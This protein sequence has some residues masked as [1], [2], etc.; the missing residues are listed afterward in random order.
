MRKGARIS[1]VIPALNEE[2]SIGN[3]LDAIPPWVDEVIVG[4]NGSTDGTV[5]VARSHGATVATANRRG[6]GS[7]CLAA[8]AQ[9]TN[10]DIVVYLDGDF[11]DHPEQM[12]RLV[13]PIVEGEAELVIGSRVLGDHDPGALTP[14]ARFGNQLACFLMRLI[15]GVRY[16]DLGPFRAI[17]YESLRRL[18]MAD[19]DYGW[20]VEMQIKAAQHGM[21]YTEAPVD[22][23][24]RIG[25]SKV[26]GTLRGII[27]AGY[28]ILGTI[29]VSA[30]RHHFSDAKKMRAGSDRVVVFTRYPEPGCTK[31]RLIP[32]LGEQGAA[33][34]QRQMTKRMVEVARKSRAD[35]TVIR[36]TGAPGASFEDWLGAGFLYTDQGEG[37]LGERMSRAFVDAF[38][39]GATRVV[40]IGIDCPDVSE[41]ILDAALDELGRHDLVLGPATD[42]GYYLIGIRK[43]AQAQAIPHLFQ[44]VDWG[45]E[46]V[47]AQTEAILEKQSLSSFQ[48]A[49]LDDVDRPDDLAVW[50]RAVRPQ[51]EQPCLSIVIPTL[52]EDKRIRDTIAST[53]TPDD[54][55]EIIV[56][57]G[58]STDETVAVARACG[59]RVFEC[60]PGR[61]RQMN[62][63]AA[64]ASGETLLFLH[65]DTHLPAGYEDEVR[66]VLELRGTALGAFQ[67]S[68]P[69]PPL[70]MRIIAYWANLRSRW[71][72]T[73]YGDQA[74]FMRKDLFREMGGFP[75][76][77][78]MED[79]ALV[80]RLAKKGSVRLTRLPVTTSPHRWEVVGPWRTMVCN[81]LI[82][83][84]Y[85]LGIAPEK[86]SRFYR[87]RRG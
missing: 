30:L 36:Y 69:S 74:L 11:S 65:G 60:G 12:D 77:P 41:G 37:D 18:D 75:D 68:T 47:L 34:L 48:F 72:H 45:T 15:W 66:R 5:S 2:R 1:V 32:K 59:V 26:S 9:L 14:Q 85:Y 33:D 27:G 35:T 54:S 84:A 24:K 43:S 70:T 81:Q 52:N 56:C 40:L 6:Y 63:G 51:S 67:F 28:K 61:A 62:L 71:F 29:F 55:I 13:D 79:Y 38:Q 10:P 78:I 82:V 22:Y 21:A 17:R 53:K 80:R 16:T 50:E 86:L 49:P 7:A 73:P 57:D 25:V 87:R 19:P 64:K 58:G 44:G 23:R 76:M 46:K 8:M 4:D 42:G 31:T 39:A 83:I 3:V 20:T